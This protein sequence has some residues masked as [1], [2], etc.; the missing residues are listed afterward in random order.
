MIKFKI[1]AVGKIKESYYKEAIAEY[2]KRIGRFA[3]LEIVE[4]AETLFNGIPNAKE[5]D[6]ILESEGKRLQAACEGF[7]VLLDVG[8]K[9]LSSQSIADKISQEMQRNGTFTFVIGGSYGTSEELK[10]SAALRWSL[11]AVTLPH[12]L[13]RVVLAEQLYR[14]CCINGNVPYHK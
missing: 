4:V 3:S 5:I 1:V 8:G 11:S 2:A 9:A 10:K 7:V 6:K 13:C 12:Q 14:I